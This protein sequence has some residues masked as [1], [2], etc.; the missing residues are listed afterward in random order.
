MWNVARSFMVAAVAAAGFV[1]AYAP[2]SA[3]PPQAPGN[4]QPPPV[5]TPSAAVDSSSRTMGSKAN[6]GAHGGCKDGAFWGH[7]NFIDHGGYLETTPY[8]ARS[9]RLRD[10][11]R[12]TRTCA[13]SAASR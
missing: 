11:S 5:A 8:G 13:T 9:S 4:A 2:L 10:I 1:I 7:V 6:F 3:Q 12:S